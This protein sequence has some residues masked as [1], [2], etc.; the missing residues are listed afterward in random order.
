MLN[1]IITDL[2]SPRKQKRASN[3]PLGLLAVFFFTISFPVFA[4]PLL[5]GLASHSE[6]SK[7][8]FI[9]ALYLTT[10]SDSAQEILGNTEPKRIQV[11]ITAE[12]FSARRF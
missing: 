3:R 1:K 6:L 11:R 4:E 9:G 7:E 8:Q 12:S 5:N 10:P 2:L